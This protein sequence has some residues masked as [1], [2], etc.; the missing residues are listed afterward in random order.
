[1]SVRGA[2]GIPRPPSVGLSG[3]T[4][5]EP[6]R[7]LVLNVLVEVEGNRTHTAEHLGISCQ[8]FLSKLKDY[9]SG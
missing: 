3:L 9:G 1:M 6:E 8:T 4:P 2:E 7:E 5:K